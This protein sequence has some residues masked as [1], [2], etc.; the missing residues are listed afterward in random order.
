MNEFIKS[1]S[2]G[3]PTA[4]QSGYA[5]NGLLAVASTAA[6]EGLIPRQEAENMQRNPGTLPS[7]LNNALAQGDAAQRG[8]DFLAALFR[9]TDVIELRALDPMGG[10]GLSICGRLGDAAE[11]GKLADFINTHNG[12]RNI[13]FGINPRRSDMAGTAKSGKAADVVARQVMFLDFDNKDAPDVDVKWADTLTQL[14]QMGPLATV[15]SGNGWHVYL[16]FERLEGAEDVSKGTGALKDAMD[17]LGADNVAD[18]PRIARMPFTVNLPGRSKLKRGYVAQLALPENG[19]G[20][21]ARPRPLV[22]LC[23]EVKGVAARLVLPGNGG[24]GRAPQG[25]SAFGGEKTPLPA[26]SESAL[27]VLADELPNETGGPFDDRAAWM[28]I[29]H[30]FV[31]AAREA[32]LDAEGRNIF[33]EWSGKWGGDPADAAQF[34]DTCRKP[35]SGWG[36]LMRALQKHNP[37]GWE[38][39]RG[40]VAVDTFKAAPLT[41][42][43]YAVIGALTARAHAN[44][45]KRP[46]DD[47]AQEL[48]SLKLTPVQAPRPDQ[49]PPREWLYGRSVIAGFISVLVAP[50]GTGKSSLM[51]TEAVAMAIGKTLFAG[52]SPVGKLRV[53]VHGAEDPFDEHQRRL[54]ALLK[55]HGLTRADLGDRLFITSG[56]DAPLCLAR[57]GRDGPEIMQEAVDALVRVMNAA[58][59]DVLVLDPLSAVHSLPENDN[60]AMNALVG[61]LRY[62]ADKTGAAIILVHHTSKAAGQDMAASGAGAARGASALVDGARIVR[63]VARMSEKEAAKWGIEADKAHQYVRVDNGKSN[64]APAAKAKWRKLVSVPLDN[65][66]AHYPAGDTV[67]VVEAWTP[68]EP[69][70]ATASELAQVQAVI[71]GASN[72]PRADK[73]SSHWI[74]HTVADALGFDIGPKDGSAR[75]RS[76]RQNQAYAHV[77]D[78]TNQWLQS[79]GLRTIKEHCPLVRREVDFVVVGEPAVLTE[80]KGAT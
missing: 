75:S 40:I 7:V 46:A 80:T 20:G 76:A 8:L 38:R 44:A 29:G 42:D 60:T 67:G 68:P 48:S 18:A 17:V 34:F 30:A 27:R 50:G 54:A 47:G 32:G 58:Q 31:G 53:W 1:A 77:C 37:A 33:V 56:R 2:G 12:H 25:H 66:T 6:N 43:D 4:M 13:Y 28:E 16:P 9:P 55:H 10:G 3:Q 41:S 14:R 63:Q 70:V 23:D 59:V 71:D 79:G 52:E 39:V 72:K 61:A 21:A 22:T 45:N 24:K 74:G 64:L 35:G 36:A 57:M 5:D 69:A 49:I 19:L 65:G 11:R 62:I 51:L 26:P 78:L 73:R 15:H